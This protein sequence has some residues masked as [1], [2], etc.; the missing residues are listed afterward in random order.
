MSFRSAECCADLLAKVCGFSDAS[1]RPLKLWGSSLPVT[2]GK[3]AESQKQGLCAT[4]SPAGA[5]RVRGWFHCPPGSSHQSGGWTGGGNGVWRLRPDALWRG[6]CASRDASMSEAVC[7]SRSAE[8]WSR[9]SAS[10]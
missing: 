5:G 2:H 6:V 7:S 3:A 10:P 8:Y 9:N 1:F 4:R